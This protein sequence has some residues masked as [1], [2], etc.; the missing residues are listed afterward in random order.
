M[1]SARL[2]PML[3]TSIWTSSAPGGGTSRFSIFSTLASPYSWKRTMRAMI[4]PLLFCDLRNHRTMPQIHFAFEHLAHRSID[5]RRMTVRCGGATRGVRHFHG[6]ER[7]A[8]N[9]RDEVREDGF[10]CIVITTCRT[11]GGWRHRDGWQQE[12]G[13]RPSDLACT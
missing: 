12:C 1:T 3:F 10:D 5:E 9:I 7:L 13:E 6:N 2:R 11:Y 8:R 4:S